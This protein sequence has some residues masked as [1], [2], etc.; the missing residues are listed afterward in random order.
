[1]DNLTLE[2][3]PAYWIAA[4]VVAAVIILWIA[5]NFLWNNRYR[6][7]MA[8]KGKPTPTFNNALGRILRFV[9]KEDTQ[10]S[11][12][13]KNAVLRKLITWRNFYFF[14][15]AVSVVLPLL[16]YSPLIPLILL[17]LTAFVRVRRVFRE[18]NT[19]L[20]RMFEVANHEFRYK[21]DA[22]LNPWGHVT[23]QQ[24]DN[25]TKP[26]KTI[27]SFPP[28][29]RVDSPA[30][31]REFEQH[32]DGTVAEDNVWS[33]KWNGAKGFVECAPVPHLPT[34]APYPG[35]EN[36]PWD[37]IPL[38]VGIN[39]EIVWKLS[40]IPHLLVCGTTGGG[41]SVL[42]RNIIFHVIQHSDQIKF[43][44]VDLKR[45]E[46]SAFAKY[47]D[48]VLG[49]A[50]NL[51]DGVEVMRY[52][53]DAMMER[54]ETMEQ[55]GVTN[56]MD[57]PA[58]PPALLVMVDEAYMFMAPS[59]GKTDKEKEKDQL[60][61][62]ATVIIGEIARLG[63]AAGVHLVLATQRP[64]AKVIYGEI[65]ANLGARYLAGRS[66]STASLMILD[67]DTGTRVPDIKG[68][69]VISL[70]GD[71]QFIQGYFAKQEWID[72]WL[73]KKSGMYDSRAP[74]MIEPDEAMDGA[75]DITDA[76]SQD[77]DEEGKVYPK[78]KKKGIFKKAFKGLKPVPD[79]NDGNLDYGDPSP[80]PGE[81]EPE[82]ARFEP[83]LADSSD[84][85]DFENQELA[86]ETSTPLLPLDVDDE[87]ELS[88][89]EPTPALM[90][91]A[92]PLEDE[93]EDEEPDFQ[94]DTS[95]LPKP[96]ELKGAPSR[97]PENEEWDDDLED[98]FSDDIPHN[99]PEIPSAPKKSPLPARPG[100]PLA[101][102]TPVIPPSAP[103]P[104]SV[105]QEKKPSALPKKPAKPVKRLPQAPTGATPSTAPT[106]P[107]APVTTPSRSKEEGVP[108]GV[109]AGKLPSKPTPPPSLPPLPKLPPMP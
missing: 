24:W 75:Y 86:E 81:G 74:E 39:G 84:E 30:K 69:G 29:F 47:E 16:G 43:L 12:K 98:I 78:S 22:M 41:K 18:R 8:K 95:L 89:E 66:G 36:R 1:M 42:Q 83:D 48:T 62:E 79:F 68:R 46:L 87:T 52:A 56:F 105:P 102:S 99:T 44:G 37:E 85:H 103:T 45:V 28:S 109:G 91:A 101:G 57:L 72:E 21:K 31:R 49:I 40:E 19:I 51:N 77:Q 63:R 20:M 6:P 67:S 5:A 13:I 94:V 7:V 23:I 32:F 104:P 60:H 15:I 3:V 88:F 11:S 10:P 59:G 17:F 9:F 14:L 2:G 55:I 4:G 106:K 73:A 64:D 107:T 70:N 92:L 34:M 80:L 71:E 26:G 76:E 27:V 53:R 35:S 54:Y 38:G 90:A 108:V 97:Q 25:L 82:S 100:K 58:P 65:K 50:R 93:E 33:Y 61:G 96:P